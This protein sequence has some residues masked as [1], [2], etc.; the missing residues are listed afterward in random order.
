[1]EE[2]GYPDSMHYPHFTI[3]QDNGE[4]NPEIW[5]PKDWGRLVPLFNEQGR[6]KDIEEYAQD[7]SNILKR[8]G[9]LSDIRLSWNEG[10]LRHI[11]IGVHGGLDLEVKRDSA[12]Y[13]PHN[14]GWENGF[15]TAFVA[16]EYCRQLIQSR[17]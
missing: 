5:L 13:L 14:L 15:Y 10:L 1:M 7:L 8:S 12:R 9:K 2:T 6:V 16:M 17:E 11:A 3:R 4:I